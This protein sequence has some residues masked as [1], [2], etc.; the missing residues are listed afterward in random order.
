MAKVKS[1]NKA[2]NK[3]GGLENVYIPR[4]IISL[5]CSWIKRWYDSSLHE[6]KII[7]LRLIKNAF[8]NC[9][10]F[11]LNLAFKRHHV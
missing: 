11:P 9:F 2:R 4:K 6:W 7:P 3:D 1:K 8:G 10:R 5:Q